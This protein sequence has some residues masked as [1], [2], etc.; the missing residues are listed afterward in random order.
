MCLS[1]TLQPRNI[2]EFY[3]SEQ[4]VGIYV[5]SVREICCCGKLFIADFTFGDTPV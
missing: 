2:R 4:N 5:G 1:L 3:N